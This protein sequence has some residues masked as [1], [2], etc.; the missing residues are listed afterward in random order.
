MSTVLPP[1]ELVY[2]VTDAPNDDEQAQEQVARFPTT[3]YGS[4]PEGREWYLYRS[5]PGARYV[6]HPAPGV[7][8]MTGPD[9]DPYIRA[10]TAKPADSWFDSPENTE[11]LHEAP[12]WLEAEAY[13]P[14]ALDVTTAP[15]E[16]VDP[17]VLK[18]PHFRHELDSWCRSG[19]R[20]CLLGHRPRLILWL[21]E[22]K[23]TRNR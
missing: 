4:T 1:G 20:S 14:D 7:E 16:C 17:I 5:R 6:R 2:V 19:T 23:R 9:S 21:D 22:R 3:R 8:V 10:W 13:W 18:Q 15:P 11:Q 12:S